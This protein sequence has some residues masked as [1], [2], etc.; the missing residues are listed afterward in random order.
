MIQPLE[1]TWTLRLKHMSTFQLRG[2]RKIVLMMNLCSISQD[3]QN[4]HLCHNLTLETS[5]IKSPQQR[6]LKLSGN[7]NSPKSREFLDQ[8]IIND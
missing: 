7:R 8:L 4:Y 5:R 6:D 3:F 1:E 2:G